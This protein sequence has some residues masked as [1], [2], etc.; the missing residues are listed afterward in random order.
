MERA[1]WKEYDIFGFVG[2]ARARRQCDPGND[3]WLLLQWNAF[4]RI[5]CFFFYEY[6]V[7]AAYFHL[8]HIATIAFVY[9]ATVLRATILIC[10][11]FDADYYP[12]NAMFACIL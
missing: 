2:L 10:A 7:L 8:L 5:S 11:V 6:R 9:Q 3:Y 4:E 12:R 1:S